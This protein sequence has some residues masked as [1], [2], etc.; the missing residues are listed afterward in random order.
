MKLS[1]GRKAIEKVA[2]QN[3]V[4]VEEVR[5]EIQKAIELGMGD[6]DPLAKAKWES[7]CKHGNPPTPEELI[8]HMAAEIKNKA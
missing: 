6:P 1:K 4:S 3:G 8:I 5:N 7:M 2:S